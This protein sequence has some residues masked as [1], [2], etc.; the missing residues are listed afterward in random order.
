MPVTWKIA[1]PERLVTAR[2]EGMIVLQ[3]I[4]S[5][6]DAV[7]VADALPYAKIFDL[8]TGDWTLSDTDMLVLGARIRAYPALAKFGPLAIVAASEKQNQQA[9]M[10]AT[11]ADVERPLEIFR[12]EEA[13][14]KWLANVSRA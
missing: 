8:G 7:V 1:P 9:Q 3:D 14:R 12:T 11:L 10:F 13:A 2:G 4:E 5:Y 6:L